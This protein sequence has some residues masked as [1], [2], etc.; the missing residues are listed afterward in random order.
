METRSVVHHLNFSANVYIIDCNT[1]TD[2]GQSRFILFNPSLLAPFS[3]AKFVIYISSDSWH[4]FFIF[5]SNLISLTN[6]TSLP[7]EHSPFLWPCEISC[8]LVKF[9]DFN[10]KEK[11]SHSILWKKIVG[12]KPWNTKIRKNGQLCLQFSTI[13]IDKISI[14]GSR[15]KTRALVGMFLCWRITLGF[16]MIWTSENKQNKNKSFQPK[17]QFN[18]FVKNIAK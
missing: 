14:A 12:G 4:I 1:F 3:R 13:N 11:K 15:S 10:I 18:L 7:A 9:G 5:W 8:R 16:L 17:T 6:I 2:K